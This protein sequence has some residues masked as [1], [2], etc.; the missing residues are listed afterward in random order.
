[1][2]SSTSPVTLPGGHSTIL[3][4]QTLSM[5][6]VLFLAYFILSGIYSIYIYPFYLS[7]L[8]HLPT[9][10]VRI[11]SLLMVKYLSSSTDKILTG[12]PPLATGTNDKPLQ[13]A[14]GSLSVS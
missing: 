5:A 12:E 8:R 7:P 3:T 13:H 14:M 10:K 9:P 1:M 6:A 11:H 4:T 2:A